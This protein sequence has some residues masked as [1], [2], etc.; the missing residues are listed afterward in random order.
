MTKTEL[1]LT[2]KPLSMKD[3]AFLDGLGRIEGDN[4]VL[5]HSPK[6]YK[7]KT[8]VT[9]PLQRIMA[10]GQAGLAKYIVMALIC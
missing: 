10:V 6:G 5:D 3:F 7:L 4:V 1:I 9:L 8:P 2:P